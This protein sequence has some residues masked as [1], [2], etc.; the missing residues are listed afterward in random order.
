MIIEKKRIHSMCESKV[1]KSFIGC[2]WPFLNIVE[3]CTLGKIISV[4]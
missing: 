3:K 1:L 2:F 4:R